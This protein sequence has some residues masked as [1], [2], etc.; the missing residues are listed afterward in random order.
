M[1][2]KLRATIKDKEKL[3]LIKTPEALAE[4][5]EYLKDKEYI[6]Y[7]T[8]TTG[9][10]R[11]DEIIGFSV[12]A[13][14]EIGY[15]VVLS[16]WDVQKQK[17]IALETKAHAKAFL[18]TLVG[19]SLIM[20][21]AIFDCMMTESNFQ[22]SFIESLH[23]DT[24][25]LAHLLN[26]NRRVGLK[27][28]GVSIFGEDA[29]DEQ[30]AMRQSVYK[31]GGVMTKKLYELYKADADLIGYYGAKDAVLTLKLFYHLVPDLYEQKLDAF[32]YD[33]ESMPLLK[34]PTYQLNTTGLRI[35][36]EKLQNLKGSLEAEC[37]EARAFIYK[38]IQPHIQAKY[39]GTSPRN[40]F[41]IGASQ[42]LSW[43]LFMQLGNEFGTLTYSGKLVCK[44]LDIKVPYTV[45]AKKEFIRLCEENRG[46]IFVKAGYFNPKTK[47]KLKKDQAISDPWKYLSTG[48][49]TLG[50]IAPRYKWV[51]KLL[52]YAKAK[53]LLTTYVEGIQA[54]MK[55]NVIRPSFLQHGTTSGRYSSRDPNFQNLPRDDKRVKAC[56][57]AR[58]GMILVGADQ[59]QL[60]PRTFTSVSQ[61]KT[62]MAC[63]ASGQDFYSVVGAPIFNK[64]DCVLTK[65][66]PNS[67]ANKYS[68]LRDKSKVIALATPYG[69]TAHQQATAM[70]ISV[71]EAQDLID[72]Y[73]EDFPGVKK[74]M[75]DSHEQAKKNG[76][77]YSLFGR[78]RRIPE[79]LNI[80]RIYGSKTPHSELPYAI[81]SLL[82]LAMN[83]RVQSSA[84]S[85]MNRAAIA[86][87]RECRRRVLDNYDWLRV[88]IITQIHDEL[89]LEGPIAL[90]QEMKE[91]LKDCMENTVTLPGVA[92]E[93]KPVSAYNLADLK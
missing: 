49:V 25:V 70:G 52:E 21:N 74:M 13:E 76:V 24:M 35:D 51:A 55:Y 7:D 44:A 8:E 14:P 38:E 79:A 22:V 71:E 77:V 2:D 16:Y 67:F 48:K 62:L 61:D 56:V 30:I 40:T 91:V 6:A 85:I 64:T 26:E 82:N 37:E 28:L 80:G 53:K 39:A 23:T 75:L 87:W 78:P 89:V 1:L 36:P 29:T 5:L 83:H 19:K 3:I 45:G 58:P 59:S 31:N 12:C 20:H 17:L 92:L 9:L 73:F 33:E 18:E 41:N 69:R 15:Y 65:S 46:K 50:K 4:L 54:R 43:L 93:A 10:D 84:A 90:E 68:Q 60:E 81:R 34:G 42:Q 11:E 86:V 66:A 27:E 47:K 72:S 57:V 32:F 63:F 88:K